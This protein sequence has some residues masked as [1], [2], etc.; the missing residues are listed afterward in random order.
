MKE[1]QEHYGNLIEE[2]EA[3]ELKQ[4][5]AYARWK[6]TYERGKA[7]AVDQILGMITAGDFETLDDLTAYFTAEP[8]EPY[9]D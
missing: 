2:L 9:E 1:D 6:A 4:A 8:P 3:I 5:E 7:E